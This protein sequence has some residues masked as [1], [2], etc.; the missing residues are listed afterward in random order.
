MIGRQHT[1]VFKAIRDHDAERAYT[2]MKRHISFVL[3]F[4]Q[5]RAKAK[6]AVGK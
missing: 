2:A 6:H 5:E 4:F 1:E 3:N